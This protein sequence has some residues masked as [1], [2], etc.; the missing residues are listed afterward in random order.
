MSE[1]WQP[2]A[3]Y[4]YPEEVEEARGAH[5]VVAPPAPDEQ[6]ATWSPDRPPPGS[7]PASTT[8]V[9]GVVVVGALAVVIVLLGATALF[10]GVTR[11]GGGNGTVQADSGDGSGRPALKRPKVLE[12]Y[13][14]FADSDGSF[15]LV[16][17]DGWQTALLAPTSVRRA[18]DRL[19]DEDPPVAAALATVDRQLT[20]RGGLA[21]AAEPHDTDGSLANLNLILTPRSTESLA[22]IAAEGKAQIEARGG[23][24]EGTRAVTIG[25]RE[26]LISDITF[27]TGHGPTIQHQVYVVSGFRI[28]LLTISGADATTARH[29]T[30]S[31]RVP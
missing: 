21:F 15:A 29:I 10:V 31:L 1:P 22:Q 16:V 26:A 20:D 17:P 9:R 19:D 6:P 14:L 18:R 24:V 2:P 7:R 5:D 30:A 11:N 3:D 12:G 27:E 13:R 25:D 4:V 8:G 23:R 28:Y